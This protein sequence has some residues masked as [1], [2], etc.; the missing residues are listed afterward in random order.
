MLVLLLACRSGVIHYPTGTDDLR[1]AWFQTVPYTRLVDQ[2]GEPTLTQTVVMLA[3][4]QVDC[5]DIPTMDKKALDSPETVA[6]FTRENARVVILFLYQDKHR[7][8]VSPY[9]LDDDLP[10]ENV[11]TENGVAS[12]AYLGVNEAEL[13]DEDGL[14]RFYLPGSNPGDCM[15]VQDVPSPGEVVIT[16]ASPNL[17]G[18]FA[19]DAI[20]VSGRFEAKECTDNP[21]FLTTLQSVV[22]L[23]PNDFSMCVQGDEDTPPGD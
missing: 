23:P 15:L 7:D 2:N 16:D 13:V 1:A 3:N 20:D 21:E 19:L 12:A 17:K 8:L 4:T 11:T 6:V 22:L 10:G 18:T 5:A 9:V 14:V